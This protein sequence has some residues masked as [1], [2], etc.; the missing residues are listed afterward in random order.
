MNLNL[1]KCINRSESNKY[2]SD[3]DKE[4]NLSKRVFTTSQDAA[5]KGGN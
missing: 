3:D 1:M 4:P 5:M 2:G